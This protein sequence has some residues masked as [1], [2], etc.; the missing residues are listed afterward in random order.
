MIRDI[1]IWPDPRLATKSLVVPDDEFG[2]LKEFLVDMY[3][4]LYDSGG[5]GLAAI[6][7]GVGLRVF[8]MDVNKQYTFINPRI[9][10]FLGQKEPKNEG[11]LSLPGV[12]EQIDRYDSVEVTYQDAEGVAQ[13]KSFS[14]LEAQCCQHE[15][16]HL[17]GITIPDRFGP[18]ARER[19]MAKIA[20]GRKKKPRDAS[21]K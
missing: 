1:V 8:V 17:D 20:K 15:I 13:T 3:E 21:P 6:Q 9:T 12:V 18:A 19:M 7:I 11:C 4:T 5:I 2:D 16:D 10:K 14:G